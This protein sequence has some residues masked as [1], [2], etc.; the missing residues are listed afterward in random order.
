MGKVVVLTLS[1]PQKKNSLNKTMR[2]ELIHAFEYLAHD[3][4]TQA[5]VLYGGEDTF[6]AGF[7]REEVMALIQ[8]G[9]AQDGRSFAKETIAFQESILKFPKLL[10]AAISGYALGGGFDL[11]VLCHLRVASDTAMF[12]H[13]E[14]GFGGCPIFFPYYALVGRGKALELTLATATRDRFIDAKEAFKLGIVNRLSK[15][16][17]VL[18]EAVGYA[19]E[20]LRSPAFAVSLLLQASNFALDQVAL[21]RKEL[22]FV[23]SET[24]RILQRT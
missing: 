8:K 9:T 19:K 4:K 23:A 6:C 17:A 24:A 7:D 18:Q 20:I 13:P 11:A 14:I 16:G 3:D 21:N 10:I 15:S 2:S 1:R 12:G 5:V 22:D